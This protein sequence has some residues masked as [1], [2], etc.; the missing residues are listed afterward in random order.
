MLV[1]AY[2]SPLA[3]QAQ[4]LSGSSGLEPLLPLKCADLHGS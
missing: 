1:S 2:C 4:L 3:M